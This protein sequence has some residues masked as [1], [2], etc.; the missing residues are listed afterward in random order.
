MCRLYLSFSCFLL[1][2]VF[3]SKA[4]HTTKVL[5][6]DGKARLDLITKGVRGVHSYF[7]IDRGDTSITVSP[8]IQS[9]TL[10]YLLVQRTGDTLALRLRYPVQPY[11]RYLRAYELYA[12]DDGADSLQEQLPSIA[13][14]LEPQTSYEEP[15]SAYITTKNGETFH[16]QVVA[17]TTD[18]VYL[19]NGRFDWQHL[20]GCTI[21]MIAVRDIRSV[22][23]RQ[24]D[25]AYSVYN[26]Q[27]NGEWLR[28]VTALRE[29]CSVRPAFVRSAPPEITTTQLVDLEQVD[30]STLQMDYEWQH[31]HPL[32]LA[33]FVMFGIGAQAPAASLTD[34][35]LG[36]VTEREEELQHDSIVLGGGLSGT[37]GF[38]LSESLQLNALVNIGLL[39]TTVSNAPWIARESNSVLVDLCGGLTYNLPRYNVDVVRGFVCSIGVNAG[40]EA[41]RCAYKFSAAPSPDEFDLDEGTIVATGTT[42]GF[43][44]LVMGT[45]S[46]S[47]RFSSA[48]ALTLL[49]TIRYAP[50]STES[51]EVTYQGVSRVYTLKASYP[52]GV[53]VL[54]TVGLGVTI[55][56]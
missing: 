39:K 36:V 5:H 10:Q 9:D 13:G 46:P 31:R 18:T 51:V 34:V 41:F 23:R 32:T 1:L 8:R 50:I 54:A 40:I 38:P 56:L 11:Q 47:Y 52:T 6:V 12:G 7:N 35:S 26:I 43:R 3:E 15:R 33:P 45:I 24:E 37:Y 25:P 4:Q 17:V 14:N 48:M 27:V 44:P 20:E 19:T 49:A 30:V 55:A 2:C 53:A 22:A 28:L 29:W 16:G 42:M 21:S